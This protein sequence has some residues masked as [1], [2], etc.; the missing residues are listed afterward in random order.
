MGQQVVGQNLISLE[1]FVVKEKVEKRL[2]SC[3]LKVFEHVV[4]LKFSSSKPTKKKKTGFFKYTVHTSSFFQFLW[5]VF[6]TLG[7]LSIQTENLK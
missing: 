4:N 2:I 6:R 5:T 7:S 3:N 1:L